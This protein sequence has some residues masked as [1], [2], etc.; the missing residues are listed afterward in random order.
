M[1]RFLIIFRGSHAWTKIEFLNYSI[2][3]K[4]LQLMCLRKLNMSIQSFLCKH[5]AESQ[6]KNGTYIL[7]IL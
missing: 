3:Q 5:I 7:Y 2:W 6:Q 4:E 1:K